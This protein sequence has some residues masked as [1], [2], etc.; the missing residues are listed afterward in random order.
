LPGQECHRF[1]AKVGASG[2]V[3]GAWVA[4]DGA[5][6]AQCPTTGLSLATP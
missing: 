6:A 4:F 1:G 5:P 3:G 2:D